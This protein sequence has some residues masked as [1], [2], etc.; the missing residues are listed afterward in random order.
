M[1][2]GLFLFL[3]LIVKRSEFS[4]CRRTS[5]EVWT[6]GVAFPINVRGRIVYFCYTFCISFDVLF[7][8]DLMWNWILLISL[9]LRRDGC[10]VP[11]TSNLAFW[12]LRLRLWEKLSMSHFLSC[13]PG[14][15]L[16]RE[17]AKALLPNS[18]RG[19]K[20]Q[21]VGQSLRLFEQFQQKYFQLAAIENSGFTVPNG[22]NFVGSVFQ[23][24][25]SM[26]FVIAISVFFGKTM[27][28]WWQRWCHKNLL[29]LWN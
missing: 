23:G 25:C 9:V 6:N 12:I 24:F 20:L 26:T 8:F 19:K 11:R 18:V 14:L 17:C 4:F 28:S 21:H 1:L 10:S 27:I 3:L 16:L 7:I 13:L 15:D 2:L 5:F 22:S 29:L